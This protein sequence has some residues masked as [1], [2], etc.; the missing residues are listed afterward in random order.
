MSDTNTKKSQFYKVYS[1]SSKSPWNDHRTI[2]WLAHAQ[3]TEDGEVILGYERYIYVHLG[4]SGQICGIS[5]SKQLLA[6]NSEQFDSKYLEGGSVEMY[7]F[8]L[9]HIEEISV[10]CELFRDDFLKTFLL[11]PDIYFNAAEKYWLEKICDA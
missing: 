11:P 9:L 8:L 5:I 3:K 10:F 2:T 4:S 6:E 1:R 7:A